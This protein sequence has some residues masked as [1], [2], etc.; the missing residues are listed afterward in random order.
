MIA[1]NFNTDGAHRR[2]L[3]GI[4]WNVASESCFWNVR[5]L[6]LTAMQNNFVCAR[7]CFSCAY[8]LSLTLSP[9]PLSCARPRSLF[10]SFARVQMA[11]TCILGTSHP[12][13]SG[14]FAAT[15][16]TTII[17]PYFYDATSVVRSNASNAEFP[18]ET[19]DGSQRRETP[20]NDVG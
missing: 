3:R 8:N 13:Y 11:C 17:E 18:L 15:G 1:M 7:E 14:V 19:L 16:A 20:M 12:V 5:S 6:T 9:L 2:G 10:K 4:K